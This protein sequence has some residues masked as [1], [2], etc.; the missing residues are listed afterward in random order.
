VYRYS[1][2]LEKREDAIVVARR[3]RGAPVV[4]VDGVGDMVRMEA[5]GDGDR[6]GEYDIDMGSMLKE[7]V[8]WPFGE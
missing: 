6:M 2:S 8:D 3:R 4:A 1:S 5:S 7:V